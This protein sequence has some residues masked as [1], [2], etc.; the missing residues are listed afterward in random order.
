MNE[1]QFSKLMEVIRVA[2]PSAREWPD[3]SV[4]WLFNET[5]CYT[6]V[7]AEIGV[8]SLVQRDPQKGFKPEPASV[9]KAIREFGEA[10]PEWV[11]GTL[12]A[13]C[14]HEDGHWPATLVVPNPATVYVPAV[15]PESEREAFIDYV[16][17]P[18]VLGGEN[19]C[20]FCGR[21]EV[22][23]GECCAAVREQHVL[24]LKALSEVSVAAECGA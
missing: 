15:V 9:N 8:R 17:R 4:R 14:K 10:D 19:T 21:V 6:F 22:C 12:P 1:L 7:S 18:A 3:D 5:R 23:E 16:S 20:R 2:W 24:A 11:R 13:G